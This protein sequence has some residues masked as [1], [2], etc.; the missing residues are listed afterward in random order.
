MKTI[1][2][3]IEGQKLNGVTSCFNIQISVMYF[4][5]KIYGGKK[6]GLYI[7]WGGIDNT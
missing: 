2:F 3:E 1:V 4:L 6:I 7:F 5:H